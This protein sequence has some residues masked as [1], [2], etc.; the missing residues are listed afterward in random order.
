MN[1][2]NYYNLIN[3]L[4]RIDWLVVIFVSFIICF[5][6]VL[7]LGKIYESKNVYAIYKDNY[8]YVDMNVDDSNLLINGDYL[9]ING[10]KIK[11]FIEEISDINFDTSGN[12]QTFKIG[13]NGV[14]KNNEISLIK[15]FGNKQR[16]IKIIMNYLIY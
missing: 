2:Y 1:K 13:I 15:V 10:K 9:L 11:Y 12:Y 4:P 16:I 3:M 6:P 5:M 14:M 8:L 7:F